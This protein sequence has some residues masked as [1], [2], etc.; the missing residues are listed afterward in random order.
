MV[1]TVVGT[2]VGGLQ[3]APGPA[4]VAVPGASGA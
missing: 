3:G 2:V 1:G 4:G